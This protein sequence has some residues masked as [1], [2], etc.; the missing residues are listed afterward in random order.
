V[1]RCHF[2]LQIL[3]QVDETILFF[4]NLSYL[5]ILTDAVEVILGRWN[6]QGKDLCLSSNSAKL[7]ILH[8]KQFLDKT[9]G[10][11]KNCWFWMMVIF[12]SKLGLHMHS[13]FYM[14][15]S[16][17]VRNI[18]WSVYCGYACTA[19]FICYRLWSK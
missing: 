5:L 14:Y 19:G 8:H 16:F 18:H 7:R 2:H 9:C 4:F 13:W 3:W 10:I 6:V 17:G 1:Y 11:Q 15:Y 12:R